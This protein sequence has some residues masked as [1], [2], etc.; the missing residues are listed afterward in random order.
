MIC[1]YKNDKMET[2]VS[3]TM[4]AIGGELRC[5]RF[6]CCMHNLFAAVS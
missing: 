5:Y 6:D 4:C 3:L 1:F 2:S